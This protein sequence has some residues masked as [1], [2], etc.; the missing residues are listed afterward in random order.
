M[1]NDFV[2]LTA[3]VGN[4]AG[5]AVDVSA[6]GAL[7]TAISQGVW[8]P[9]LRTPTVTIEINNAAVSTDGTWAPI[10]PSFRGTG[11]RQF[12]CAA[13]WMRVRV[14]G[15]Q[16]GGAAP[17]VKVGAND[18]GC[19]FVNLPVPA[20]NG[21]GAPVDVHALPQLYTLVVGDRFSGSIVLEIS[22][23]TAGVKW[24][25]W[26][27]M[28]APG[29]LTRVATAYWARIKR[30]GVPTTDPLGVPVANLG[31][32]QP[33]G[34][35]GT[36][37]IGVNVQEEGVAIAGNPHSTLNFVGGGVTAADAGGGVA[38]ITV[39]G[40]LF[41]ADTVHAAD[42]IPVMSKFNGF[43]G[44]GNVTAALPAASSVPNGTWVGFYLTN[45]FA[46]FAS[47]IQA[48]GADSIDGFGAPGAVQMQI[49][50]TMVALAGILVSDGVSGWRSISVVNI[51]TP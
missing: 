10:C 1:A 15:L 21:V 22:E 17:S 35:S 44:S 40:M 27:A 46:G 24:S 2:T 42:F 4:G 30:V 12:T 37:D 28:Q 47:T 34:G 41:P 11:V 45:P 6:L 19:V 16:A 3:P 26:Q 20:A 33:V 29:S 48:A 51:N 8:P 13:K 18:D 43:D 50:Y 9:P 31:A 23:D 32:T 38:T 7:K 39:P 14:S 25:E 49:W 36:D 5:A